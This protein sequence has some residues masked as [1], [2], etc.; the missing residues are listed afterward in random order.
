V[1]NPASAGRACTTKVE[2]KSMARPAITTRKIKQV[3]LLG[4]G[5]FAAKRTP[6]P[7]IS[8]ISSFAADNF[9]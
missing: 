9:S 5:P 2:K 6:E 1:K 3:H 7:Q 4:L 8:L